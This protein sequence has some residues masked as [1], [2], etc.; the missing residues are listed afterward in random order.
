MGLVRQDGLEALTIQRLATELDLT[1]GAL[2]RYFPSKA[3]IIGELERLAIAE[4]G[5]LLATRLAAVEASI[6]DTATAQDGRL[7]ALVALALTYGRYAVDRPEGFGLV[8]KIMIDPRNLLPEEEARSVVGPLMSLLVRIAQHFTAAQ[9]TG[10]LS[11]GDAFQRTVLLWSG[12]RAAAELRKLA[13][14]H[15]DIVDPD[16]LYAE[17]TRTLLRGWGATAAALERAHALARSA[18]FSADRPTQEPRP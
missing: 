16:A 17:M 8:S 14:Y 6:P 5:G 15:P 9:K 10:A 2:Y 4:I 12:L 7:A 1:V 13:A 11:E 18:G 3:V